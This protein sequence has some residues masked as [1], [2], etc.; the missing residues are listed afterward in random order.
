MKYTDN[1]ARRAEIEIS[2][3][4]K[5]AENAL[6]KRENYI[7]S[8]LPEI[9][10]MRDS[11]KDNY[12]SLLR[13]IA[14]HEPD[15]GTIAEGVRDKNLAVQERIAQM[16][17][18]F[19]GDRNYL[20]PKYT[21][22]MCRDTGYI[23][24]E[25][26]DCLKN[27]LKAYTIEELNESSAIRLH[28]FSEYR[29]TYYGDEEVRRRMDGYYNYLRD[30]C[31]NFPKNAGSLLFMGSTGLG[32][33][34]LSACVAKAVREE[35]YVVAFGSAFDF[36]HQLENEYFGRAEDRTHDNLLSCDLLIIDDLGA[37]P[38]KPIYENFLY[39]IVNGRLNRRK[40]TIISTNLAGN[41]IQEIYSER[42]ASRI[43]FDY[44]LIKFDG[45][46]IRQL[47]IIERMTKLDNNT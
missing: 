26:C 16:L 40:A 3:R 25:R 43:L 19:T 37:E 14:G 34:F 32:K 13:L 11:L 5:R 1:A 46:D 22:P 6:A 38:Q 18:E 2:N 30:Y 4:R 35:G 44:L 12:Y 31:R 10:A 47:K 29:S 41:D 28:D 7:Y 9:K 21:C 20:D 36:F 23:E 15:A 17:E 42:I 24:G 45:D 8:N 27:L 39:N 33:T